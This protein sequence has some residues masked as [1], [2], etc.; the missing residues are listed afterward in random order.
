[1]TRINTNV[2]SLTAQQNLAKSNNELQTAMTRLSTGLRINSG[3][4][5]PSGMIAA[6]QLGNQIAS[7]NQ[8][9]SNTTAASNMIDTADSSLTQVSTLLNQIRSLIVQTANNSNMTSDQITANQSVIDSSLDAIDRIAQTTNFQGAKL[10]NGNLDYIYANAGAPTDLQPTDTS[11]ISITAANLTAGALAATAH[12]TTEATQGT[13]TSTGAITNSAGPATAT[14]NTSVAGTDLTFTAAADGSAWNDYAISLVADTT[15]VADG[16]AIAQI[17]TNAKTLT[18]KY[19]ATGA[20]MMGTTIN[21]ALAAV[22]TDFTVN[23]GGQ[24][25]KA[26]AGPF[27]GT[28][29]SGTDGGI[30]GAV[31]VQLIGNEGS[32]VFSFH[33]GETGLEMKN[34]INLLSSSTGVAADYDGS[35]VLTLTSLNYGSKESVQIK[36]ISDATSGGTTFTKSLSGTSDTGTDIIGTINGYTSTGQG[37]TLSI[38]TPALAMSITMNAPGLVSKA[39]KDLKLSITGGGALFQLGTDINS[40]NQAYMGIQSVDTGSLGGIDGLL[41]QLKTGGGYSLVEPTATRDLNKSTKIVDEAINEVTSLSGRLGAFQ[42]S[43]LETNSNTLSSTV[44]A[45][46]NAQ[47]SIQD[48]DFAAETANMTRAQI[49][50]QSGTAVLKIA[51]K[52]PEN[53]LALLQ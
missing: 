29:D 9:L 51:N 52:N 19:N 42:N 30:N 25:D 37:N 31:T 38:N 48:A 35:N 1:M 18:V 24:I 4:D 2:S 39:G 17:D 16:H 10:L 46:T 43:T 26:A 22:T 50:V 41:Y 47:S 13:I 12:V 21:T 15:N 45:L 5:D 6:A 44:T 11:K 36:V 27:T 33:S 32:H 20:D 7:T 40:N 14:L 8:A 53:V 49:L 34:A 28:T 3:K 23:A